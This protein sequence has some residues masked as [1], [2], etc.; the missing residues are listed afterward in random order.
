MK[1]LGRLMKKVLKDN[2]DLAFRI[3]LAKSTLAIDT[4]PT[5]ATV[6]TYANHLLAE[7]EQIA[8]Q[9]RRRT[10]KAGGVVVEPKV[11]KIEEGKGSPE[12]KGGG[13]TSPD[14]QV[15]HFGVRL[16]EREELQLQPHPGRSEAML[17]LWFDP[18]LMHRSVRDPESPRG[19]VRQK[20]KVMGDS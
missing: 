7:V 16:Q 17:D 8:H 20:G 11:K 19:P 15:L 12:G 9:D 4:T 13:K 1:G 10:E 2:T 6:M 5:E 14:L 18:A 3:Q